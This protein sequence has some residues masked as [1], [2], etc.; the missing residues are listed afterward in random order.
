MKKS[1]STDLID[2]EWEWLELHVPAPNKR[3]RLKTHSTREIFNAILY[4]LKSGCA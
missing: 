2:A 3:G 1:Y 4:I